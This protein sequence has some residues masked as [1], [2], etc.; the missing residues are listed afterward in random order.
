MAF[1][2]WVGLTFIGAGLV[3]ALLGAALDMTLAWAL[4]PLPLGGLASIL[5]TVVV[6]SRTPIDI[7]HDDSTE[8]P[9]P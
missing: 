9:L 3:G 7:G 8:N 6:S 4:I 5:I 1:H 2:V